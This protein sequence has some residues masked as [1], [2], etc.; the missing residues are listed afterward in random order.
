V[1]SLRAIFYQNGMISQTATSKKMFAVAWRRN[2]RSYLPEGR[3]SF[4]FET[5]EQAQ[6][7]ADAMNAQNNDTF[8]WVVSE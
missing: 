5:R 3:G 2:Y 6:L 4:C 7:Y 1:I 8:H